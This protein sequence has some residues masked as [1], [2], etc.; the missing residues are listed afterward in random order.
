MSKFR[1]PRRTKKAYQYFRS[2][3]NKKSWR[4]YYK[5]SGYSWKRHIRRHSY[6]YY[7]YNQKDYNTFKEDREKGFTCDYCGNRIDKYCEYPEHH[8]SQPHTLL[9]EDCYDNE[10]R[11]TCELC[12][13]SYD[14]EECKGE[15]FPKS[16]CAVY[17][18][19]YETDYNGNVIQSG[20][21]EAIDHPVFTSDYFSCNTQWQ[22]LRLICSMEDWLKIRPQDIDFFSGDELNAQFIC[23]SCWEKAKGIR[24]YQLT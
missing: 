8:P 1:L 17:N 2:S 7:S 10:Y 9:C 13:E 16:P 24:D 3:I 18:P 20:I 11:D 19:G 6:F 15:E 12:E 14:K 5:K 23:D 21:Y 22:N 4:R